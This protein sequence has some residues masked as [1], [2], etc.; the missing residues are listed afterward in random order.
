M[1]GAQPARD[2]FENAV[3]NTKIQ[4]QKAIK[5]LRIRMPPM[6]MYMII[7]VCECA[8]LA[9]VVYSLETVLL[10]FQSL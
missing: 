5:P 9:Y 8:Q 4:G 1:P 3:D 2:T 6:D 7:M 10:H